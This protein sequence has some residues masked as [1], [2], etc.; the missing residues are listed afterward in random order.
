MVCNAISHRGDSM[1]K[2]HIRFGKMCCISHSM[3]ITPKPQ[4]LGCI[5]AIQFVKCA[6]RQQIMCARCANF[7]NGSHFVRVW[8]TYSMWERLN[9]VTSFVAQS[10]CG[11]IC[12]FSERMLPFCVEPHTVNLWMCCVCFFLFFFLQCHHPFSKLNKTSYLLDL[13]QQNV[14]F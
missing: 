3:R 2:T 8:P 7:K 4:S 6:P 12:I 13:F 14:D 1:N 5:V 9:N 10:Y 11:K